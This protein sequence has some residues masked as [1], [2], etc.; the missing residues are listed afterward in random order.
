MTTSEPTPASSGES[1]TD[2]AVPTPEPKAA[3][4]ASKARGRGIVA[5]VLVV[6]AGILIP[7]A[8]VAYW[9][10]RTIT[11]AER[12]IETV[13]PLA[14]EQP[15]KDAIVAK[16]TTTVMTLIEEDDTVNEA[17]AA[18]PPAAATKLKPAILGGI[19][20][21][22]TN[23]TTKIVDS[24]QFEELWVDVNAK[25]QEE[26]V[27]AL[28]GDRNG[29]V[30]LEGDE[31]V[32]D[33]GTVAEAVKQAL[34][35]KGLTG[36]ADKQIPAGADQNIVL[37]QSQELAQAQLIYKFTIPLARY[38]LP[39]LAL[40]LVGAVLIS[41]RRARVVFGIGIASI[42]GMLLL[43]VALT[44][45]KQALNSA[46]PTTMAQG[47]LNAFWV[48][49][50]RYLSTAVTA[51][52]TV[53]IVIALLGW[54][55]GRSRPATSVRGLISNGLRQSGSRIQADWL[56]GISGFL[57]DHWRA[58]FIVVGVLTS[59]LLLLFG[60]V[61]AAVVGWYAA[62]A[63]ALCALLYFLTGVGSAENP[64]AASST[65]A[66]EQTAAQP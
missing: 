31:V 9:G 45:G 13:G 47:V 51:Y 26:L 35:D 60:N 58:A 50:T 63:L 24:E 22:V 38:L 62:V 40:I 18:L 8:V 52:L 12:Y 49:L 66:P 11:D 27:S 3:A 48:T 39:V 4:K 43:G 36:L 1:A 19:E 29:A 54:F 44:F 20:G 53:G 6:I 65:A 37:L 46:A 56:D 33:T 21:L 14:A 34:V 55:G 42:L 15:I 41:G 25:L 5:W 64:V 23:V 10:Q 57:R 17:L 28:N 16:T 7:V 32:L 30:K 61:S 2:V 59:A